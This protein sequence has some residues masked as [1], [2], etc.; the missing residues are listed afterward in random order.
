M[1]QTDKFRKECPNC[2][3]MV[4]APE[5]QS[6]ECPN[7]GHSFSAGLDQSEAPVGGEHA[8]PTASKPPEVRAH[9]EDDEKIL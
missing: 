6:L 9:H 8:S 3:E 5:P 2:G 7:C 4:E 1:S